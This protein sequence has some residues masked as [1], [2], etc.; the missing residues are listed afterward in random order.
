MPC[1][2]IWPATRSSAAEPSRWPS[3]SSRAGARKSNV[4]RTPTSCALPAATCAP[5]GIAA[6][7]T[8]GRVRSGGSECSE[9]PQLARGC[10]LDRV[11]GAAPLKNHRRPNVDRSAR[12]ISAAGSASNSTSRPSQSR[13]TTRAS[14]DCDWPFVRHRPAV[15]QPNGERTADGADQECR[16]SIKGA[17]AWVVRHPVGMDARPG[18]CALIPVPTYHRADSAC[19]RSNGAD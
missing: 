18:R 16:K 8:D 2:P 17:A 14:S 10:R 9:Q 4:Q 1:S 15:S 12:R 6:A 13:S 11:A 19:L 5:R 3:R 7:Q